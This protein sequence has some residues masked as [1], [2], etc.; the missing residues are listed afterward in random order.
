MRR[1]ITM[2]IVGARSIIAAVV[3]LAAVG[4]GNFANEANACETVFCKIGDGPKRVIHDIFTPNKVDKP[5]TPAAV[6]PKRFS[7]TYRVDCVDVD[8]GADRADTTITATSDV[9]E[10]AAR[11]YI[12]NLASRSDLCQANGDTSRVAKSGR[13]M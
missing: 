10:D 13:W 8:T 12:L 11:N 2:A 1:R 7:A 9:S 4:S 5:G 3:V 6:L